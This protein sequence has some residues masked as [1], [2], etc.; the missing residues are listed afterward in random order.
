MWWF[1]VINVILCFEDVLYLF[2]K[3]LCYICKKKLMYPQSMSFLF[4]GF[5]RIGKSVFV[6]L[7]R[8]NAFWKLRKPVWKCCSDQCFPEKI[9][10]C[11]RS[12]DVCGK[13]LRGTKFIWINAFWKICCPCENAVHVCLSSCFGNS[14]LIS[15][16]MNT[17]KKTKNFPESM[18]F[19]R[20]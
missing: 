8:I 13:H 7:F 2:I 6:R 17:R 19:W 1:H 20:I 5:I 12:Y 18:L 11:Q 3:K 15:G 14:M 10:S 9:R 16:M 4:V